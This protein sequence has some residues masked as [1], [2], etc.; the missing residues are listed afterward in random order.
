M[1]KKALLLS[2]VAASTVLSAPTPSQMDVD[3]LN[4]ALTLE[5][6]E[7]AF[8][9][10]GL[11]KYSEKDFE[12]NGLPAWVRGRFEQISQHEAEHVK[13]LSDALGD[14]AV[15]PCEYSFPDDSPKSFAAMSMVLETVG[16][17]AYLGGAKMLTDNA[18]YLTAAGSILAV[19]SRQASWVSSSVMKLEPWNGPFDIPLTPSGAFSL[20]APYIK[21]CPSSNP[22]LPVKTFPHLKVSASDPDHGSYVTAKYTTSKD[23]YNGERFVAWLDG[24][25]AIFTTLDKDGKTKVPDGL[26]GTVYAAVVKSKEIPRDDTMLSGFAVVQFPFNSMATSNPDA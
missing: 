2:F 21:S 23:A 12:N 8:Y 4:F 25:Q 20:A 17:S 7:N 18:D 10:R 14:K 26:M 6:L 16:A 11:A 9:T 19:E 3:V 22:S 1:F 24:L 5:H 15:K 13:F